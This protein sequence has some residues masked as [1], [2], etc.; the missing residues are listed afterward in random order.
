MDRQFV[1][2]VILK[3]KL[4]DAKRLREVEALAMSSNASLLDTLINGGHLK[5]EALIPALARALSMPPLD[6][7]DAIVDP[8]LVE[9]LPEPARDAQTLAPLRRQNGHVLTATSDPMALETID[10]AE[11]ALKVPLKLV[12]ASQSALNRLLEKTREIDLEAEADSDELDLSSDRSLEDMANEAPVIK[13]VNLILMRGISEGASD[14]HVEPYKNEAIVRYRVDGVLRESARHPK[15]LYPAIIS[16]L[17]IMANL[18]IAERRVPQDGRISLKLMDK[19]YD[20]RVATI[21]VLYGEGVVM[22]ILDKESALIN[23]NDMGFTPEILASYQQ[24]IHMPHGIILVTGPTGSGKTTTLNASISAI[25]SPDMKIITIEDPVEYEIN[26]VTQIHVNQKVGLTFAAGLRSVLRLDPDVAM[27]GE[28]RDG[29]TADIAIR[30]ALTGHLVFSTL[31]TND[32]PSSITRLIDMGVQP[33]LIASCLNA[34]LAQRLVRKLCPFC[35]EEAPPDERAKLLLAETDVSVPDKIKIPQGCDEC[36]MSGYSGR[37]AIHELLLITDSVRE[38]INRKVST[39]VLIKE[40]R[41][42]AGLRSLR[43]DG[44][45]KMLQGVTSAEEVHRVTQLD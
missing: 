38:L 44:I 1:R 32:A 21:P 27:I 11:K 5:E 41:E 37:A 26:G 39:D 28:I 20:L 25:N 23:L 8:E 7:A 13:M 2:D 45:A 17:K 4:L 36:K 3:D 14:I 19:T 31:H 10:E 33:Y 18:N 12:L 30:T 43:E 22:R 29:E 24:Q 40:A 34:V 42:N 15:N 6:P 16:R 35:A 9:R